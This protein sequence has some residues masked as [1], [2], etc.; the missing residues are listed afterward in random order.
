MKRA[1][2]LIAALASSAFA[3]VDNTVLVLDSTATKISITNSGPIGGNYS[4]FVPTGS[5]VWF[6][7]PGYDT[8]GSTQ[9]CHDPCSLSI[10]M[11]YGQDSYWYKGG[12]G[13]VSSR[14]FI[15][16]VRQVA[17]TG[18]YSVPVPVIGF[19][20]YE[21]DNT[22]FVNGGTDVSQLQ[23][24]LRAQNLRQGLA[25]FRIN[26]GGK[27]TLSTMGINQFDCDGSK[28]TAVTDSPHRLLSGTTVQ[29]NFFNQNQNGNQPNGEAFFN[30]YSTITVIGISSFTIANNT[31]AGDYNFIS[32]GVVGRGYDYGKSVSSS[33][34]ILDESKYTGSINGNHGTLEIGAP[35]GP[36][37]IV[38]G[39]SNTI[40]FGFEQD[41]EAI[42]HGWWLLD[43]NIIQPKV[44]LDQIVVTSTNAVAHSSST[45]LS[46]STG[47][48]VVIWD[49]PGPRWRF[50]GKRVITATSDNR[51]FTFGW[52]SDLAGETPGVTPY[53]TANGTYTVPH[54]SNPT[55]AY[56]PRMFVAKA[57]IPEVS[58]Q[59]YDPS[60]FFNYGGSVSNG[61]HVYTTT[62]TLKSL[63][64]YFHGTTSIASCSA[65][66]SHDGSDLK[67]FGFPPQD[68][69]V[70]GVLRGLSESDA[71][72]V[73]TYIASLSPAPPLKG[74]PWNGVFQPAVGMDSRPIYEW[75][76][77]GGDEWELKYGED[78]AE[79]VCPGGVCISTPSTAINLREL[80]INGHMPHWTRWL[81]ETYPGDFYKT[82]MNPP[83]DFLATGMSTHYQ[84]Y[85]A[86]LVIP[87][88][89]TVA[90][91]GC[92]STLHISSAS[93]YANN[94][95]IQVDNE[96]F[97]INSGAGTTTLSVT[98]AQNP[99]SSN[100]STSSV[101]HST[102]VY[103]TD[104]TSYRNSLDGPYFQFYSAALPVENVKYAI[105]NMSGSN[106]MSAGFQWPAMYGPMYRD[107]AL[108]AVTHR[109]D[110]MHYFHV[111]NVYD[112]ARTDVSSVIPNVRA[113]TQST[114]GWVAYEGVFNVGP[115]QD[116]AGSF[117]YL[118]SQNNIRNEVNWNLDSY[119]WYM[120]ANVNGAGNMLAVPNGDI[121]W[122]YLWLF[123]SA[124]NLYRPDYYT[125]L[126]TWMYQAQQT[127]GQPLFG[128]MTIQDQE[129]N[130]IPLTISNG[131]DLLSS[132]TTIT[133]L[134]EQFAQ[135]RV[136]IINT[137]TTSQWKTALAAYE[138]N[139]YVC[140][141]TSPA[142]LPN[143]SQGM[144]GGGGRFCDGAPYAISLFKYYNVD[145]PTRVAFI[146]WANAMWQV[147]TGIDFGVYESYT[148]TYQP[149]GSYGPNRVLC[150]P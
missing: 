103:V 47:D 58:F 117:A 39:S 97:K 17:S 140:A 3:Y 31:P 51:H 105:G 32:G 50:N 40:S 63:S 80:P 20:G 55:I 79:Y 108:W 127:W 85:L 53:T 89:L 113:S 96:Y 28:C 143:Y 130:S 69:V 134:M 27:H 86:T 141:S 29:L 15:P 7:I 111:E 84:S 128:N 30:D 67:Y 6:S 115:H 10:N 35:I 18:T 36:T 16:F 136:T 145:S 9:A 114:R 78:A 72:D 118:Q 57:L 4:V 116:I 66:H 5:Q 21:Q 52:G 64:P 106:G 75:D 99:F 46:I 81:P 24:Y 144:L 121:D 122:G 129:W 22:F 147:F 26:G 43:W 100:I 37:E 112:Q 120:E 93:T 34:F 2:F 12:N 45:V 149:Q 83:Q 101:N 8:Q 91:T 109:W 92:A 65:C 42:T 94:D 59:Y 131:N 138:G 124:K 48:T 71:K 68:I 49:A 98:C 1:I 88:T 33:T 102:G 150:S 142:G 107:L 135:N 25:Y 44:E 119:A 82:G 60:Q 90:T 61:Q 148:C 87:S 110:L 126:E 137:F 41:P 125:F 77:G 74:R 76:A 54:S 104:L 133:S 62:G 70:A 14:L 95:Y 146:A 73:A 23:V 13:I 132:S 11:E 139:D 56:P 19:H 123:N 38:A